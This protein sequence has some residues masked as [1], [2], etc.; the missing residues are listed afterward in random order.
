MKWLAAICL[1]MLCRPASAQTADEWLQ[2]GHRHAAENLHTAAIAAYEQALLHRP[3]LRAELA[4]RLGRQYLWADQ[5]G[6]AAQYLREYLA[7]HNEC[8]VRNDYGL[9]LARNNQ[10]ANAKR[11]YQDVIDECAADRNVAQL[12]MA[13]VLRWQDRPER[14][15]ELY[16]ELIQQADSSIQREARTG[17]AYTLLQ[18]DQNRAALTAF[19]ALNSIDPRA[20]LEGE[21]L[22][23]YRLGD[24]KAALQNVDALRASGRLSRD[25]ADLLRTIQEHRATAVEPSVIALADADGTRLTTVFLRAN[26]ALGWR[27]HTTVVGGQRWLTGFGKSFRTTTVGVRADHRFNAALAVRTEAELHRYSELDWTP[28]TGSA[29][30]IIA[31]SDQV[32]ID[33]SAARIAV[34]DNIASTTNR[35]TGDYFSLGADLRLTSRTTVVGA[36]DLTNWSA[37]NTRTRLRANLRHRFE[38]APRITVEWPTLL[39]R[40]DQSFDFA[41]FSPERYIESGPALTL[42]Q[43]WPQ[44]WSATLYGRVGLQRESGRTADLFGTV[45]TTVERAAIAGWSIRASAGW[46]NSNLASSSSFRRT[47]VALDLVRSLSR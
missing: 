16:T 19:R 41:L 5:P 25:V 31:P 14:A 45:R 33:V 7:T 43:R 40:Y 32:R 8:D 37:G 12:R 13:L 27:T 21:A 23:L 44:A 29:D 28:L 35:L 10:L 1:V 24:V 36:A 42:E 4:G 17:L 34:Y 46:S 26:R 30:A 38:G 20:A 39:Q 22:A 9:A 3:G 15:A 11:V 2:R 6:R 47:T 18:R